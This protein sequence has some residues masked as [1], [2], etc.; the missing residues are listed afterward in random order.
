MNQSSFD[1]WL[2]LYGKAWMQKRPDLIK[3]LFTQDATYSEKPFEDSF[4]G[5]EE[6]TRYWQNVS[7]SQTDISF[8]YK[9]I[10]NKDNT[11]LAHF[12]ASFWRKPDET[13]VKLDGI[14][15]VVLDWQNKCTSFSEWWQSQ[16]SKK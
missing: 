14:F 10:C 2:K 13:Y 6:I 8:D 16:K 1:E 5:I 11:G 7:Q 9:I 4:K 15:K 12:K 3:D